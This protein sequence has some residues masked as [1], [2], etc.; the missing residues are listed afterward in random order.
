MA[1]YFPNFD[2]ILNFQ[3][4]VGTFFFFFFLKNTA[5]TCGS[6][7]RYVKPAVP[8][9]LLW[10]KGKV[11]PVLKHHAMKSENKLHTF[12]T[13]ALDAGDWT[14]ENFMIQVVQTSF[15]ADKIV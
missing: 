15:S 7:D 14:F 11:V 3:T 8:E 9:K 4:C 13:L 6:I 10:V 5:L 2:F 1:W 12:L